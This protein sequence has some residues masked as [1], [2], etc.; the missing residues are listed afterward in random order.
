MPVPGGWELVLLLGVLVL[1]FGA[2]KL[3]NAARA[4]GQS[5]RIFK[6]E[7]KGMRSD[8]KTTDASP[9]QGAPPAYQEGNQVLPPSGP[10]VAPPLE[11]REGRSDST[12]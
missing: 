1:L 9:T 7:T 11:H 5:M 2:S 6:A 4:I 12:R 10:Q 3:P 8:G